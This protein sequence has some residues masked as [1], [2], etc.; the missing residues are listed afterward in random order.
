MDLNQK[1]FYLYRKEKYYGPFSERAIRRSLQSFKLGQDVFIWGESSPEW[2]RLRDCSDFF[3]WAQELRPETEIDLIELGREQV[4]F[5]LAP[6]IDQLKG[7]HFDR[8]DLDNSLSYQYS[9]QD[10]SSV[11]PERSASALASSSESKLEQLLEFKSYEGRSGLKKKSKKRF[12]RTQTLLLM[13]F[14]LPFSLLGPWMY[15]RYVNS[16]RLEAIDLEGR[17]ARAAV[18]TW[19]KPLEVVGPQYTLLR[20]QDASRRP[21]LIATNL[22]DGTRVRV[23]AH[24][25]PETLVGAKSSST[26]LN[27]TVM[28]GVIEISGAPQVQG[29][30]WVPGLYSL[31]LGCIECPFKNA[32]ASKIPDLV[33]MGADP[34][35]MYQSKLAQQREVQ[36][37]Q[38]KNEL[39][40]LTKITQFLASLLERKVTGRAIRKSDKKALGQ[41]L[42]LIPAGFEKG[43]K[44]YSNPSFYQSIRGLVDQIGSSPAD[45]LTALREKNLLEEFQAK[46]SALKRELY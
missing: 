2:Q 44:T 6:P 17:A 29:G 24:G 22:P 41:I 37:I 14:L 36:Q 10:S 40:E 13:A 38:V 43:V 16:S 32:E 31:R 7:L 3:Q 9:D 1:F 12:K 28:N 25:A 27:L 45:P 8:K 42:N 39:E 5:V 18:K 30:R 26:R 34:F 15:E 11:N 35:A 46:L 20:L 23:E 19:K 4:E 33:Y 21:I